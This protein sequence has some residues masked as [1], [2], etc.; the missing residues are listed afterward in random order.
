MS[1]SASLLLSNL[2]SNGKL[3][4]TGQDRVRFVRD[5]RS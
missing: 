2:S 1:Q 5:L 4:L 3:R